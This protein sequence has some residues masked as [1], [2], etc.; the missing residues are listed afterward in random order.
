M[1]IAIFPFNEFP[2]IQLIHCVVRGK[3]PG[4]IHFKNPH[5]LLLVL[6]GVLLVNMWIYPL[7]ITRNLI[8]RVYVYLNRHGK[9]LKFKRILINV[10]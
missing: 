9:L 3:Y 8:S 4:G 2:S 5:L 1:I 7:L 6:I 10:C